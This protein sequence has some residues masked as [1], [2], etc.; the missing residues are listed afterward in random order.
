MAKYTLKFMSY[1]GPYETLA[2]GPWK[3][4]YAPG[5]QTDSQTAMVDV[6]VVLRQCSVRQAR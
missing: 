4:S 2:P 1:V 3:A 5:R 6:H